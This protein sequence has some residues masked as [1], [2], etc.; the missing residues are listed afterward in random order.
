MVVINTAIGILFKMPVSFIPVINVYAEF[1][2]KDYKNRYIPSAFG[3]FYLYLFNNGF[4]GE[5]TDL[6][7]FL[8]VISISIQPFI[9]KRFDK[10]I[11]TAFDR[12]FKA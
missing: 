1:F 5:I 7:D 4:Y 3:R 6:A 10:K 2:Y 11:Q 8:F 9:Y 12:L